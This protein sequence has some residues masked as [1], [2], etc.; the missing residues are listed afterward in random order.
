MRTSRHR[1]EIFKGFIDTVIGKSELLSMFEKQEFVVKIRDK[2][3]VGA[4]QFI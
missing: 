1:Q 3:R 4:H 2:A